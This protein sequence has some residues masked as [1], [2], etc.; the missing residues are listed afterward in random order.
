VTPHA[1]YRDLEHRFDGEIPE[2]LRRLALAGGAAALEQASAEANSRC[3][4]RLALAAL[5][6]G[7][8]GHAPASGL[9]VWRRQGLAWRERASDR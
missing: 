5:R 9:D 4:D 1:F 2:H 7:A 3:C 6:A 8:A